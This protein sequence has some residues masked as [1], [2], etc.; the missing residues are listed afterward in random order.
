MY[1]LI[2][3]AF[4]RHRTVLLLL[5]M[6][7]VGGISAFQNIPKEAEPDVPIPFIYVSVV[8]QGI[9]PDDAERL[10]IRPLET[11][12]QSLEG[13]KEM[14]A[15]ASEGH[16]SVSLE[17]EAGIDN[18]QALLDVR[19]QVDLARPELPADSEEP[20]VSEVNVALFPVIS[21]ILAGDVPEP[22]LMRMAQTLQDDIETLPGVLKA[23]IQGEREDLLEI[24]VDP[25]V[26]ETYGID[27]PQVLNFVSNNNELVAAGAV[28]SGA[29]R[30]VIK[31]PGVLETFDDILNLPIVVN[32]DRVTL[33][34]DIAEIRPTYKDATSYIRLNGRPALALDVTKRLGANIIETIEDVRAV[35][36]D[37]KQNWPETVEIHYLQDKSTEVRDMLWD[38]QNNVLSAIVLVMLV[39][40]AA[41]GVRASMLV[42]LAIPGSFFA[43]ML[44]LYIAGFSTNIV[45]LFSLILVVGMLVDG[46]IVVSELAER[47]LDEGDEPATA[48]A[49]ASKRMSWPIIGSTITTLVVFIPLLFWP[50]MIGKF[51]QYL[52]I[53]V[54]ITL[55]ASLF[56]ALIF[57]PVVGGLFPKPSRT[58]QKEKDIFE[59]L[60]RHYETQL[61]R[62]LRHPMRTIVLMVVVLFGSIFAY[63]ILGKGVE[64]FPDTDSDYVQMTVRARGDF[65]ALEKDA[66][67]KQVE[68]KIEELDEIKSIY[69]RT[70]IGT[71]H[72]QAAEDVVGS[73][74]IEL[75]NW[76][77]RRL[78]NEIIVDIRDRTKDIPGV[79]IE[80]FKQAGGPGGDKPVQI[81]VSAG[82]PEMAQKGAELLIAAMNKQGS[83]VDIEDTRPL[84]GIEWAFEVNR[85]RAAKNGVDV[86]LIGQT[87]QMATHGLL[88]D[89]YR[90]DYST[91][92][93]DIRLRFPPSTKHIDTLLAIRVPTQNGPMPLANFVTA[94]PQQ[95][96]SNLYRTDGKRVVRIKADMAEGKLLDSELKALQAAL[97]P[98]V[99]E[100]MAI[101]PKLRIQVKGEQE[102][103]QEAGAFLAAAFQIAVFSMLL[104]LVT[105]FN[106]IYQALVVL[107]AIVFSTAGVFLALL[108]TG[109]PFG[110]VMC[111]IAL[112]ALAGI[113]VNNNIVLIDTF[114]E[115]KEKFETKEAIIE[116]G[117][118][119]LRPVLLTAITT[120]L[121]LLPMVFSLNIDFIS[122]ELNYGAPSTLWWVQLS[123]SIA[124]G[125]VFATILT[126]FL[127]PA[128]LMMGD[129]VARKKP[130]KSLKSK[131]HTHIDA[132]IRKFQSK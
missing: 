66:L 39:I 112:I 128:L 35:A 51:M 111:G 4:A 94:K 58:E 105:Q 90:P 37:A 53:T 98:Q 75:N 11:E 20:L 22:Q 86:L 70:G 85:E 15:V 117:K 116:T 46:A 81:E 18:K 88:I 130:I 52:P 41:L 96:V 78:A 122:R 62:V 31:V 55:T 113:V 72:G 26:I 14:T 103:Q 28:D 19:E 132:K 61:E 56:M 10:I 120:V 59:P 9:S 23:D 47:H 84:P 36:E 3:A 106:N 82:S 5:F 107:S 80:V 121:G 126:L 83:F 27:L 77:K 131:V 8:H 108:I 124:G 79:V 99:K 42:G 65:A 48:F 43:G 60:T 114:N 49:K 110:V 33:F 119:R 40:I 69:G 63:G 24:R 64:F 74:F 13:L 95:K 73:I 67:M 45:V 25:A 123:T 34:R 93:V 32:E 102:D 7:F 97:A 92:D 57:M 100:A 101:D 38:L 16:A 76:K 87:I 30:L 68:A 6:L 12:L 1:A 104:I 115:L 125:L 109:K 118:L 2:D 89:K 17:F 50:G 71:G 21:L 91:D 44:V 129:I 29:G 54:L 127:T